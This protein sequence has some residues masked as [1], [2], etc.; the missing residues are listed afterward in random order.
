[1]E[2]RKRR[3]MLGSESLFGGESDEEIEFRSLGVVLV[4][5]AVR[6]CRG[7]N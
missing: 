2:K 6:A 7:M 1:M 5:H 3:E 4:G